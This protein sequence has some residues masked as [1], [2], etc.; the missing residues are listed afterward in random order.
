MN[1]IKKII[2]FPFLL[3]LQII[4][5]IVGIIYKILEITTDVLVDWYDD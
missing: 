4:K 3:T 1:L 5:G 2:I